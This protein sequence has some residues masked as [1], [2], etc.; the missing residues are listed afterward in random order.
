[1]GMTQDYL[2]LKGIKVDNDDISSS[3]PYKQ[4][5][6]RAAMNFL[7][8]KDYATQDLMGR[9][10]DNKFA[11]LRTE[12][13]L[14]DLKNKREQDAVMESS[15][16]WSMGKKIELMTGRADEV[17]ALIAFSSLLGSVPSGPGDITMN[18]FRFYD[19][20]RL[21][22]GTNEDY[23]RDLSIR[24]DDDSF[25]NWCKFKYITFIAKQMQT[26]VPAVKYE[27][28]VSALY[29]M[30][31]YQ[32][33]P[34]LVTAFRLKERTLDNYSIV[35]AYPV[36]EPRDWTETTVSEL[37]DNT[38]IKETPEW[39]KIT[40]LLDDEHKFINSKFGHARMAIPFEQS[41]IPDEEFLK[42]LRYFDVMPSMNYVVTD[43]FGSWLET[44]FGNLLN[45]G[46]IANQESY[47]A[48]FHVT[49]KGYY[50]SEANFD[51]KHS[52]L[53]LYED[54][55]IPRFSNYIN[56]SLLDSEVVNLIFDTAATDKFEGSIAELLNVVEEAKSDVFTPILDYT[57]RKIML[58]NAIN[59]DGSI[60]PLFYSISGAGDV[61]YS[62]GGD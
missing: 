15:V 23:E 33:I 60:L 53:K 16:G 28:M 46:T 44:W 55:L 37:I 11:A 3:I 30:Q 14:L 48:S 45:L 50:L 51:E 27:Q 34:C 52:L 36:L 31:L 39:F 41:E 20:L 25:H 6:C 17:C 5:L 59:V 13:N 43:S 8:K 1:M 18:A 54:Y 21:I 12:I 19:V 7:M 47:L 29:T 56:E 49:I 22:L 4:L 26:L 62:R 58:N 57:S 61:S 38:L 2:L 9:Y 10:V 42:R 24:E 32:F 40:P 35:L